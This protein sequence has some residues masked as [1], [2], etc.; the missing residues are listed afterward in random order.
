VSAQTARGADMTTGRSS[1]SLPFMASASF[2]SMASG[3]G[4][5]QCTDGMLH[6]EESVSVLQGKEHL[7][8][9]DA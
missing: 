7:V 2:S 3:C 6:E 4:L 1:S 8:V 5:I 9:E